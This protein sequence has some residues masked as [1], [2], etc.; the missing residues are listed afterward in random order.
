MNGTFA[1]LFSGGGLADVGLRAA[2]LRHTW[3]IEL[4]PRRAAVAALNGFGVTVGDVCELRPSSFACPDW[5]HMSPPCSNF[6]QANQA[7]AARGFEGR[8]KEDDERVLR[9]GLDFVSQLRPAWVS[10]ENVPLWAKT[11]L[12]TYA[13]ARL[14]EMGYKINDFVLNA[15]D[16][17]VAQNRERYFLVASLRRTPRRP[18][19]THKERADWFTPRWVS[20]DDVCEGWDKI[21]ARP[22]TWRMEALLDYDEHK[23]P[24]QKLLVNSNT[25][26]HREK[27]VLAN[28][29]GRSLIADSRHRVLVQGGC[30]QPLQN[31]KGVRLPIYRHPGTTAPAMTQATCLQIV[32][33]EGARTLTVEMLMRLAGLPSSW[34]AP[35]SL[36]LAREVLGL[37]VC[38]PVMSALVEAQ[39]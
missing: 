15:A 22:L 25:K 13:K 35:G 19:Q 1:T 14:E 7:A 29:Q 39:Q 28:P 8:A 17:G 12:A 11:H 18:N 27:I 16:F 30:R 38:P 3:G 31:S 9:A 2:G 34:I 24:S 26:N 21:D 37:G 33:R 36:T 32:S 20:W 5:L 10:L 4:D 6:S 23:N